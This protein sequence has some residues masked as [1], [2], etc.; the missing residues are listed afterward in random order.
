VVATA[1]FQQKEQSGKGLLI[2]KQ[3]RKQ[4]ALLKRSQ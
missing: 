3:N 1:N 2:S 4:K